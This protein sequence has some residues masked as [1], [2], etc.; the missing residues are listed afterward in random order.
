MSKNRKKILVSTKYVLARVFFAVT[1][2][3]IKMEIVLINMESAFQFGTRPA[4]ADDQSSKEQCGGRSHGKE[5]EVFVFF[6]PRHIETNRNQTAEYHENLPHHIALPV[7]SVEDH[8]RDD[9]HVRQKN[10]NRQYIIDGPSAVAGYDV[11][12]DSNE[13]SNQ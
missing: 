11:D 1:V 7:S 6:Q 10:S 2:V 3:L 8:T 12:G 9:D 4:V 5:C 13:D